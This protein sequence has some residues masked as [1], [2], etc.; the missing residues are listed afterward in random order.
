MSLD[1]SH[2]MTICGKFH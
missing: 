1:A 2:M